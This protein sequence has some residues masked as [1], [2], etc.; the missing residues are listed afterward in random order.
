MP[1]PPAI[2]ILIVDD[3]PS[4]VV[5]LEAALASVDCSLVTAHSGLD[6]LKC[7]LAQDF[8][9]IL[10]DVRMRGMDGFQTAGLIRARARSQSTPIMF[11]TAYDPSGARI[12]EG[13]RLGGIDYIYKCPWPWQSI[14]RW[15]RRSPKVAI[16]VATGGQA[17]PQ[18]RVLT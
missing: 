4:N 8:A 2:S 11:M 17:S 16:G 15:P 13:Y 9:V 18:P 3:E 5:A 1:F 12:Q 14:R 7:V 10:L 6:A